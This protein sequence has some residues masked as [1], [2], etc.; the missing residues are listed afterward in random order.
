MNTL[1]IIVSIACFAVLLSEVSGIIQWA[2]QIFNIKRMK[3]LDC[4]LCLAWWLAFIVFIVEKH[5]LFA[6][7]FAGAS[8]IIA[9]FISKAIKK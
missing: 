4:P 9:I 1:I 3:P 7:L 8:S 6:P 5:Y 2:K